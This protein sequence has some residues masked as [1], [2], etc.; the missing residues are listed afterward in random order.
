M[1]RPPL[2]QE[3]QGRPE[4]T[5]EEAAYGVTD[6][7]VAFTRMF[8]EDLGSWVTQ[9]LHD[10]TDIAPRLGKATAQVYGLVNILRSKHITNEF[11]KLYNLQLPLNTSL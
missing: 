10:D 6:G 3:C 8:M 9:D 5:P 11:K 2:L 7:Y 4:S 1:H